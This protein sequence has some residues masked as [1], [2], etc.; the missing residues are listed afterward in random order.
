MNIS[1]IFIRRPVM[2]SLIMA[3]ILL[4]GIVAYRSLPVSDLPNVDFP[5]IVVSA[6]LPGA[7][8]ETMS[9]SVAT[10]LERQFSTIEGI[11][12]MT[13]VSSLGSTQIT[14]Q[15]DLSRELDAA[16]QDVQT[17]ISRATR[18]LPQDM[19]QPPTYRKVNPADQP[20]LYY[21]VTSPSLQPWELNEYAD[22]ILAQRISMISGVAQV[23]IFGSKKYAIRIQLD[24]NALSS[25]GIGI[26]EV[27]E[28]V[29][30]ANVNLPTGALYGP[31]KA[32]TI[33]ATGQLYNAEAY[34]DVI[35]AYRDGSPVRLSELGDIVDS[36][37]DDR[38][39]AWFVTKDFQER[40][41][42]LA[43]QRQPGTNTV[44]VADAV[45]EVI[46]SLKSYLPPSVSLNPLY[47]R[48]RS[49]RESMAEVNFT[50]GLTLGLVVMVI[51]LFL[52]NVSATVIPS[53]A[54]PLSIVGTFVAM[55]LF[56]FSLNN[57]SMMALILAIG[58]VV[59][60]AIVML[61]N[62]VRHLE[63]GK[64][65]LQAALDG[66]REI[67]F[68]L[69]SMTI[70]LAAVFIPVLLMGGV[71]GRL[72]KEFAVSICAA[73]LISG[74][75]SLTLTPML[76]SRFLKPESGKKHGRLYNV[77]E[78]FFDGMFKAYDWS[79]KRVLRHRFAFLM[80]NVAILLV[81]AYMF[82]IIPK[83]FLS[84]EDQGT[85]FTITEAPEGTSFEKMVEYQQQVADVLRESP[86]VRAFF[87]AVGGGGAGTTG[88]NQGRMF[89]HLKPRDERP[90]SFEI[91]DELRPR[92][93]EIPGV[94]AFMQDQP[95]IR[96]GGQ[97][98]KSLYQFTVQSPD[99]EE[100]YKYV[101]LLEARMSEM[102]ELKDVTSNLEI[103]N[104]QVNVEIMRDKASAHGVSAAEIENTLYN[105]YGDRWVSTIYA[106]TNQFQV[107]M[108]LKP[109][110]QEDMNALSRL[111]VKTSNDT[112]IPLE[113]V[114]R[115]T[116]NVGPKT[117]N[118]YGQFPA[119]TISFN[120]TSGVSL[121]EAVDKLDKLVAETLPGNMSTNYQGV[122]Q[123]FQ[124][125]LSGLGLLL[126]FSI[127]VIYLILGIL[128][129]S[130]IHPLTILSGLP[131]AGFGALLILLL[132]GM[133][134]NVYGFVGLIML[135][136][137]VKKNA[138]MQ[139]DFAL[140]AQRN[141]G[142]SPVEAI[143]QG[144]LIRF[145]PIMMTTM[146]ALLGALPLALG[147]GAGAESRRTL[148]L[149]VVGGLLFSQL[150]TLYLT[151]VFYVYMD[152]FQSYV[153]KLS[154]SR[155]RGKRT[156]EGYASR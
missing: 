98:T 121:S 57:I 73:I 76:C 20:I 18:L 138:I 150:I 68:T 114:A 147:H 134:L 117:I 148:G 71:I 8:P 108:E 139:I 118:H 146:A 4:F 40:A 110:Y 106:P 96:I 53:L 70:S 56:G 126:V 43:I 82:T 92:L 29:N 152:K 91:I 75:V 7:S 120:L 87:S 65:P 15:F 88:T 32:Y 5:T 81:T 27:E 93:A 16:A 156:G 1:G 10:P 113:T 19:P 69:V 84:N 41:V 94:S 51:F 86:Y 124:R 79:L 137:I 105:A 104:P 61:E 9:S 54:L 33:L 30:G 129:E 131:S 78:R 17:A 28:A 64:K 153:P 97:L 141:E 115:F 99:I 26:N 55:Y 116:E 143:Y 39:A 149:T 6:N 44:A 22:T 77:T 2:T 111:Y 136:G 72:F 35:V 74:F 154:L 144:C 66:S 130:F 60:D 14:I 155:L 90:S 45:K 145:R 46:P 101:P 123:E 89:M 112:L 80:I 107:I 122:A 24:P 128:Y 48:S 13:S 23:Q 58:F 119:V 102:P 59:D 151:P 135:I 109:E 142:K 85:I 11:D 125:S 103:K 21:A 49:I 52:R 38:N 42:I 132:F 47:D 67:S 83:G 100:L 3:A 127:L 50:M 62:I 31:D 133:E 36:I 140:D 12:S 34:K 37:E 25:K 63:M 95:E